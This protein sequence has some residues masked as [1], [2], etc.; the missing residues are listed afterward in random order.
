MNYL[1]F[2]NFYQEIYTKKETI[3]VFLCKYFGTDL[4]G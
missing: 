3:V 2:F 4:D 1:H